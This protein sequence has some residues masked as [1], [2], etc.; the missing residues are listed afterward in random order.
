M[1]NTKIYLFIITTVPEP[2]ISQK[3]EETGANRYFL[4]PFKFH[5]FNVLFDHL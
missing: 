1:K 4:K 2:A 3:I 5:E